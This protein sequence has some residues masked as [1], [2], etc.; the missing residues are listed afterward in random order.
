MP[1]TSG[2]QPNWSRRRMESKQAASGSGDATWNVQD[3]WGI[4][5]LAGGFKLWPREMFTHPVLTPV[6]KLCFISWRPQKSKQTAQLIPGVECNIFFG[7]YY[8]KQPQLLYIIFLLNGPL[9]G[10]F[11]CSITPY[12]AMAFI[13]FLVVPLLLEHCMLPYRP[14]E[15]PS[16]FVLI[17]LSLLT[18][19]CNCPSL[20]Y[21]A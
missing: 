12:L 7:N 19:E 4:L 9:K 1:V 8:Q 17:S 18:T 5:A 6:S 2:R 20:L 11:L 16:C 13:T 3:L 14:L 15:I 21:Q 10:W